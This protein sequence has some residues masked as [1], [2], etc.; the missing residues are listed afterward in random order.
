[1]LDDAPSA[2]IDGVAQNFTQTDNSTTLTYIEAIGSA[3]G[4]AEQVDMQDEE[5]EDS[6]TEGEYEMEPIIMDKTVHDTVEMSV[7]E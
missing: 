4:Q 5:D 2:D 3:T 1:M 6:D 7:K